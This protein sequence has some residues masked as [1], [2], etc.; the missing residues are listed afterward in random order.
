MASLLA[1]AWL[2]LM[3][4]IVGTPG[5]LLYVIQLL[6]ILRDVL[7]RIL[8]TVLVPGLLL[9]IGVLLIL[10]QRCLSILIFGQMVAGRVSLLW[11]CLRLLVLVS[12]Y[13]LLNL[14]LKDLEN[15]RGVW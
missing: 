1:L 4:L 12:I 6:F 15:G 13:L 3:A 10:L 5:L 14:L 8:L 9:S 7:V 11:V 2:V